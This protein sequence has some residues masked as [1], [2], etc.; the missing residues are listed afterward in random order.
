MRSSFALIYFTDPVILEF[1]DHQRNV[2]CV[3]SGEGVNR[4]RHY[5]NEAPQEIFDADGTMFDDG[6]ADADE[7][8]SA[9]AAGGNIATI[10]QDTAINDDDEEMDEGEETSQFGLEAEN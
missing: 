5:L 9:A 3:F 10:M 2:F 1:T 4:L 7:A 8:G 6:E